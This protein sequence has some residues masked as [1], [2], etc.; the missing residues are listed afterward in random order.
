[1]SKSFATGAVVLVE[2]S[3]V[4]EYRAYRD[5]PLVAVDQRGVIKAQP[6]GGSGLYLVKLDDSTGTITVRASQMK[7]ICADCGAVLPGPYGTP[8][9]A[10]ARTRPNVLLCS[11]CGTAEAFKVQS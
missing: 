6:L 4:N 3:R 8:G 10:M 7:A 5:Q 11:D 9:V 1:M 2:A